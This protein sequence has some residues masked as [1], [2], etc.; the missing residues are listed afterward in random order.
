VVKKTVAEASSVANKEKAV[1]A[2]PTKAAGAI[3]VAEE[4][5]EATAAA[6]KMVA[7][8]GIVRTGAL[9]PCDMSCVLPGPIK[10]GLDLLWCNIPCNLF[11]F[12]S[13]Y[14]F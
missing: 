5:K 10:D 13:E 9:F 14:F 7:R 3:T 4:R 12:C 6:R 1:E 11:T 8:Y 2:K